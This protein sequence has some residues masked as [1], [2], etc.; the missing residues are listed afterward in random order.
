MAVAVLVAGVVNA[1]LTFVGLLLCMPCMLSDVLGG[2]ALMAYLKRAGRGRVRLPR[3]QAFVLGGLSGLLG[4]LFF[5]GFLLVIFLLVPQGNLLSMLSTS[6]LFGNSITGIPGFS[7]WL[8]VLG[9][10]FIV[11]AKMIISAIAVSMISSGE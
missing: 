8:V 9:G 7:V 11:L 1:A 10:L 3:L 2:M 6:E 5:L 4:S